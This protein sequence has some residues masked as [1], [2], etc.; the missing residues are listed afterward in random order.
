MIILPGIQ[1]HHSL[2]HHPA[3]CTPLRRQRAV[4]VCVIAHF[5]VMTK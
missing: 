5:D 3:V 4:C 1:I 2:N